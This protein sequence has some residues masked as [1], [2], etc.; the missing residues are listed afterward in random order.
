M[1]L[2]KV[3]VRKLSVYFQLFHERLANKVKITTLWGYLSLMPSCA[4]FFE[5]RKLRLRLLKSTFNAKIFIR[6]LSMSISIGF[7]AIRS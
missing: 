3:P 7:S 4:G 6:S 2:A 5:P 1:R